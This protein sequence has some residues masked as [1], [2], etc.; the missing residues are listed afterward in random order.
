[1]KTVREFPHKIRC[2]ENLW[3]PMPDG[4]NLAAN[5]SVTV[6]AVLFAP[7]VRELRAIRPSAV[8][9][10]PRLCRNNEPPST[11]AILLAPG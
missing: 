4:V 8:L 1:M 10:A 3:I 2:V 6:Y 9:L 11:S 7:L 5:T